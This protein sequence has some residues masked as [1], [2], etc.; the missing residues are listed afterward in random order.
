M[1]AVNS[2]DRETQEAFVAYHVAGCTLHEVAERIRATPLVV[3]QMLSAARR[4]IGRAL[5]T[6]AAAHLELY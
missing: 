6:A 4:A 2:L 3:E 5:G 1:A